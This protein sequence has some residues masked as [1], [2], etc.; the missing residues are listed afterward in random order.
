MSGAVKRSMMPFW[1]AILW[2][3]RR[4]LPNAPRFGWTP[5]LWLPYLGFLYVRWPGMAP[6]DTAKWIFSIAA[7]ILFLV[8]YFRIFNC[9][10]HEL[11]RLMGSIASLGYL[12]TFYTGT[13]QV[14]IIYAA[15]MSA[16]YRNLRK[17]VITLAWV[18]GGFAI[19]SAILYF[20]PGAAFAHSVWFWLPT[21]MM[22]GII[23]LANAWFSDDEAKRLALDASQDEIRR[24]AAMAERERIGRDLHDLLGHTLTLI[25]VKAELA[26]K[27]AERDL[28]GATR[29]IRE[30]ERISRDALAQVRE[31]VGGYRSGGLAGELANARVALT[32]ADVELAEKI[33]APKLSAT[34]D[35]LLAMLLREAVTNVVRHSGARHCRIRLESRDRHIRLLV[36][37]DGRGGAVHEGNGLKGMRERLQAVSGRLDIASGHD[38]TRL[39]I[40]LPMNEYRAPESSPVLIG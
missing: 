14:F 32:A 36:E 28:E 30:V 21:L 23:G 26:A 40:L 22:G 2:L 20:T 34:Q 17:S 38:G 16:H 24:L 35:S 25:T 39:A 11:G 3:H 6:W 13:G 18:L 37:D 19:E 8:L 15:A 5:Y 7:T 1:K 29:E 27:F 12:F 9:K 10:R 4:L 33:D 31:A